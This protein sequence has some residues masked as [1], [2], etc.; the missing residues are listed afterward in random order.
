M[1]LWRWLFCW[2]NYRGTGLLIW[3]VLNLSLLV[4]FPIAWFAPLMKAGLLPF[5]KL[6]E[7]SVMSGISS[8]LDKDLFLA[9]IVILFAI[10]APIAKVIGTALIQFGRVT[11]TWKP[12]IQVMG[13]FA[14]ADIFL[15][16]IYIVVAKGVGVGRLEVGWGLYL[17]T[18]CVLA[19]FIISLKTKAPATQ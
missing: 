7:L 2:L 9:I 16:A 13:K 14:M 5:F 6:K 1:F 18:A 19:G 10:I 17:F 12:T 4:L 3:K 8:L 11:D 15:V